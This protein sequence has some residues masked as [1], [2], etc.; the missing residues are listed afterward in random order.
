MVE[1]KIKISKDGP[2]IVSGNVDLSEKTIMPDGENYIWEDS[3][4]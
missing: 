2:Y 3:G 1:K 4:K